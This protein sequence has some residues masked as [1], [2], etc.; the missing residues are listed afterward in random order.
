MST[1]QALLDVSVYLLLLH[2]C[3]I[4]LRCHTKHLTENTNVKYRGIS[5]PPE[6]M[7]PNIVPCL[8]WCH[9]S[10]TVS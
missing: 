5:L 8:L 9:S 10:H 7:V 4:P 1:L 3:K 2:L 6:T